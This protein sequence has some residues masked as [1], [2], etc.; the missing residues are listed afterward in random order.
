MSGAALRR[1]SPRRHRPVGAAL[2]AVALAV[3]VAGACATASSR[4]RLDDPAAAGRQV[5]AAT[6]PEG[7]W[8]LRLAWEYADE[9]GPVQGDGVLRYTAPD[10]LR[11]DLFGPGDASMSVALTG[12][13]LRSVGQIR[14]VRLPPPAFLYAAAGLFRPGRDRPDEAWRG[15]GGRTLVYRTGDG[16]LRFRLREDR[17][18]GVEERRAGREVRRLHLRWSDTA[19]ARRWPRSAE[20]RDFARESR[21]RWTVRRVRPADGPFSPEIYDLPTASP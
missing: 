17:L 14:D 3:L 1:P 4:V 2:G 20:F 6:T 5:R 11:L 12:G 21:A 19:S 9:R 16:E 10:S 13:R 8:R 15:E 18:V 7:P